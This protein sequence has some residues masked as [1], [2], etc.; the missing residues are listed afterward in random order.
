MSDGSIRHLLSSEFSQAHSGTGFPGKTAASQT[1][2]MFII[3]VIAKFK[4]LIPED[5]Q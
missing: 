4:R 2:S 5:K 1:H 3:N